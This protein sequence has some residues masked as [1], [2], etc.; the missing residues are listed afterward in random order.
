MRYKFFLIGMLVAAAVA[1]CAKAGMPSGG[2]KDNEPPKV[3]R[4]EPENGATQ[5]TANEFA[6]FFDEYVTVK[7]ADKNIL[8]SPPM[9]TSPNMLPKD[10]PLW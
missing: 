2:P 4:T 3:L 1:G 7:D 9:D 10:T 6:I 5:W 8:V